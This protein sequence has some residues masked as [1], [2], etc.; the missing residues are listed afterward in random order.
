[1]K[2]R[3]GDG[4][5]IYTCNYP[6]MPLKGLFMGLTQMSRSS[7]NMA[8]HVIHKRKDC[9]KSIPQKQFPSQLI[10]TKNGN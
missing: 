9:V 1:M 4:I 7:P 3:E 10:A 2:N 5:Y 8:I 6:L